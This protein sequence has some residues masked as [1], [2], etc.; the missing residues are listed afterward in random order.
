MRARSAVL[1]MILLAAAPVLAQ[2]VRVSVFGLFHPQ[3]LEVEA[4]SAHPLMIT[5]GK[6]DK[7]LGD[8]VR[9]QAAARQ[10]IAIQTPT[11][12][13]RSS[14]LRVSSQQGTDADFRLSV[15]GKIR[16]LYHGQLRVLQAGSELVPVIEMDVEVA[17]ASI[18][19]AEL[20]SSLPIEALK[21][22]AVVTRSYLLAGAPRHTHA[23][24]CDTT[25]CQFLRQPPGA[26][27]PAAI[28]AAETRGLVLAWHGVPFAAMYSARCG[29]TTRTLA[30]VGLSSRDYP[31]FAVTCQYCRQSPARW[32]SVLQGT[33]AELLGSSPNERGRLATGRKLGWNA[34]P[35]NSYAAHHRIGDVLLEGAGAGHGVGLC[36]FGAGGMARDGYDFRKILSH[37]F[38]NTDIRSVEQLTIR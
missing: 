23:D 14:E 3:K 8:H 24:F 10:G 22:Q 36:Q 7:V 16:R 20:P 9:L 38:P 27:S 33:D 37:Y 29:G 5:A 19:A 6:R 31:Y 17:V 15:P 35:S 18:V 30:E 34:V 4:V 11:F 28:S 1:A 21:A 2:R 32:S 12:E 13:I 26:N 25:H